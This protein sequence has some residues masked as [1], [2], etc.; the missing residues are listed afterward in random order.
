MMD[1]SCS[2]DILVQERSG[3]YRTPSQPDA[4]VEVVRQTREKIA[5]SFSGKSL[6]ARRKTI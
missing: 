2:L 1:R 3:H 6:P 5:H 4:M